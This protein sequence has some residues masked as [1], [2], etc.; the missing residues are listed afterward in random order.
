MCAKLVVC[1][2]EMETETEMRDGG[3]RLNVSPVQQS[4]NSYVQTVTS[5]LIFQSEQGLL[6]KEGPQGPPGVPG[7]RVS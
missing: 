2:G 7:E 3:R 6:G 1:A 5:W 4:D